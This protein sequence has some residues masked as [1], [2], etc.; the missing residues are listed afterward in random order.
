MSERWFDNHRRYCFL[1][2]KAAL[3][4]QDD[5]EAVW[6]AKRRAI[7]GTA[8]PIGFPAR[9]QLLAG[10]YLVTEELEGSDTTELQ[11]AGLTSQQAA[12]VLAAIG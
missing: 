11:T 6:D 8:I 3:R 9:T 7:G 10:G 2:M 4:I 5:N 12:A 1:Q